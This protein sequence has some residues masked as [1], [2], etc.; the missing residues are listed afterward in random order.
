MKYVANAFSFQMI[1]DPNC[2]LAVHELQKEEFEKLTEGVLSVV[3]HEDLAHVLGVKYNRENLVLNKGDTLYVAQVIGGRLPEGAT[4]L[5]E[6]FG[7]KFYC[8]K[9]VESLIINKEEIE[10]VI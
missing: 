4:E 1:R 8:M 5:P 10:A 6:G 3:G 2:L 7:L 9:I